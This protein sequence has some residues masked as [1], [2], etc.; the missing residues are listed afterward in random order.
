MWGKIVTETTFETNFNIGNT[1]SLGVL[2]LVAGNAT[3]LY[4]TSTSAYL[5][6]SA[7]L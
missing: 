7:E 2:N 3:R 6:F 4:G 1:Y 5:Q